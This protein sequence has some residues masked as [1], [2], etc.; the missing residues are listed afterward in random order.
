[1]LFI[2]SQDVGILVFSQEE[3]GKRGRERLF[4]IMDPQKGIKDQLMFPMLLKILEGTW[5][6]DDGSYKTLY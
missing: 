6:H 1:M 2:S 3:K 5:T 4:L